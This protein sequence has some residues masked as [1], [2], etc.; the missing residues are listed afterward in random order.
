MIIKFMLILIVPV[1]ANFI[2]PSTLEVVIDVR[3][4]VTSFPT[5]VLPVLI[6]VAV[7]IGAY[8]KS[9]G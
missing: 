5:E 7:A 8:L 3:T 1:E 4:I 6:G 9:D 2:C